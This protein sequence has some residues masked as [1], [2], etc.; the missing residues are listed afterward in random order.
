MTDYCWNIVFIVL[1]ELH[2][3]ELDFLRAA[4]QGDLQA[5]KR[6]LEELSYYLIHMNVNCLDSLDRNALSL[7]ILN[8]HIDIIEFLLTQVGK[9]K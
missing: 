6:I 7:A 8:R 5:L 4:G 2:E 3:N 9:I 1:G